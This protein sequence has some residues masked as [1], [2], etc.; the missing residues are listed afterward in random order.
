MLEAVGV[1]PEKEKKVVDVAVKEGAAL[2]LYVNLLQRLP[3]C[4]SLLQEI[5]LANT[6]RTWSI[7]MQ[8]V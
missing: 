1:P 8:S 5:A 6:L 2:L 7:L 3:L 4:K